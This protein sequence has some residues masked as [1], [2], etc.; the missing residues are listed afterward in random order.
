MTASYCERG[1]ADFKT[2]AA[3]NAAGMSAQG[4]AE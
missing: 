1:E 3:R 2:P 4:A